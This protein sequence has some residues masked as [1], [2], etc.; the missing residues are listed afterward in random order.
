MIKINLNENCERILLALQKESSLSFHTED[1]KDVKI[2]KDRGLVYAT[3]RETGGYM[4]VRL[5]S[6]GKKY[7]KECL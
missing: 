1:E 2:L 7:I 3:A 5:T 4:G 6:Q